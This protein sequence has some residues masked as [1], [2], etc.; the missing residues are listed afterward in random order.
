MAKYN[1]SASC[2]KAVRK[3]ISGGGNGYVK[4]STILYCYVLFHVRQTLASDRV[5]PT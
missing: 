5:T 1:L 3:G 4:S 2:L